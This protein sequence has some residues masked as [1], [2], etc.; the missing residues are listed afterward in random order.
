MK[1]HCNL[2]QLNTPEQ[3][4]QWREA[5]RKNFPTKKKIS[6]S[7]NNKLEAMKEKARLFRLELLHKKTIEKEVD[8]ECSDDEIIE[9]DAKIPVEPSLRVIETESSIIDY[10]ILQIIQHIANK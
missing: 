2:I 5:R 3:I 9:V 7:R 4:E 6:K 10:Q 1:A 8:M